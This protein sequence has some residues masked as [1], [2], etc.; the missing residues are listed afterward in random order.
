M[1]SKWCG[2]TSRFFAEE[3]GNADRV[4]IRRLEDDA[5]LVS[6]WPME[7]Y[8][9]TAPYR[10]TGSGSTEYDRGRWWSG[11]SIVLP[12]ARTPSMDARV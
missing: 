1:S 8:S 7:Y 6:L 9:L 11:H 12:T 10:R 5:N 3:Q 2:Q 4:K